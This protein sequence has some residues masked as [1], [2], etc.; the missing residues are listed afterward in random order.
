GESDIVVDLGAIDLEDDVTGL[1][2]GLFGRRTGVDLGHQRTAGRIKADAVGDILGHGLD[3]HAKTATGHDA[4][5][6]QLLGNLLDGVGRDREGEADIAAIGGVDL[7]VH[8]DHF[9]LEVE[10]RT[11]RVARVDGSVDLQEVAIGR[12]LHV[13]AD[14]RNDTGGHRTGEAERVADG[15]DP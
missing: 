1:E 13:A 6:D 15:H 14:S 11:T 5:L 2:A 7:G 9:A 8:T 4:L 10:G 3:L 12:T